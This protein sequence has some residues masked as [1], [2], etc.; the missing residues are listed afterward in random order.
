[1]RNPKGDDSRP[2]ILVAEDDPDQCVLLTETLTDAGFHVM[3]VLSGDAAIKRLIAQ[4]FDLIILD[5]LLPDI[6]GVDVLRALRQRASTGQT[7]A[8]VI[9]S[10]AADDDAERFRNLGANACISKPYDLKEIVA[11][12][13]ALLTQRPKVE[14]HA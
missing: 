1:M 3:P 8:I 13:Y 5:S 4:R 2:A 6:G 14:E 11:L 10:F 12:V 7:P 9:S